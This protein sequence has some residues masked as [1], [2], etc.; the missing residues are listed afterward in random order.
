[1]KIVGAIDVGS[2][3]IRMSCAQLTKDGRIEI[4]E[5]ARSP[6]RLG[7]EVFQTGY[8]SEELLKNLIQELKVY[9]LSLAQRE[10]SEIRTYATSAFR[11]AQNKEEVLQRIEDEVG[12]HLEGISGG[13]EA[14][15]L[16]CAVRQVVDLSQGTYMLADLGGGSVE[17]TVV[18]NGDIQFAESFRVGTVRL[19]EMF[20]YTANQEKAFKIWV[21][22]FLKDFQESLKNKFQGLNFDQLIITGGNASAIGKLGKKLLKDKPKS[23]DGV[24]YLEKR[25]FKTIC[26]ELNR[27]NFDE[28]QEEL[29]LAID[30]SDV[31]LSASYVFDSLLEL[32]NCRSLTIPNVGVRDG[33][34]A[35]LLEEYGPSVPSTVNQ[36]ITR[37]AMFYATKYRAN[38]EHARNV[39]RLSTQVF[40]GL[41]GVHELTSRDRVLLEASAILHDI[42]RFIRSSDHHKHSMYLIRNMELVGVT[43]SELK[44]ISLVA[45][46]HTRNTPNPNHA[47]YGK[48]SK[49]ERKRVDQLSAILRVSDALD[50]EHKSQVASVHVQYVENTVTFVLN[51]LGDLSLSQWSLK[52]KKKWFED[53]FD[54][55]LEIQSNHTMWTLVP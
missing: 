39:Q 5:T 31:I 8:L 21:K 29:G 30:R 32:T 34:L 41:E 45:R 35:E 48:L 25:E 9:S 19:L 11:E 22:S 27:L 42:G 38:L 4:L 13:K 40:D 26:K 47:E 20:Q 52:T 50:R 53:V 16:L 14:S 2:N 7:R 1:M 18:Q 3:A 10:C 28:R 46:Y 17:I 43:N 33:I 49:D 12:I 37:S 23:K 6:I 51:D 44:L 36:Q 55:T 54:C 24:V 15:I